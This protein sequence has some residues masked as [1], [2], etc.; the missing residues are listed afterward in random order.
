MTE[1]ARPHTITHASDVLDKIG[2][3]DLSAHDLHDLD[4]HL[5]D[6]IKFWTPVDVLW[7]YMPFDDR[8]RVLKDANM[9]LNYAKGEFL[10]V[11]H[12][13]QGTLAGWIHFDSLQA[14]RIVRNKANP[15]LYP[16]DAD[17]KRRDT[18]L[19]KASVLDS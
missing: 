7:H 8:I 5:T 18:E 12:Q 17:I 13:Q 19:K 14:M 2:K 4:I 16:S 11:P 3:C 15:N 9:N 1:S 6:E 10:S